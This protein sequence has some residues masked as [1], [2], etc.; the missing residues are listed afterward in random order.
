M[1]KNPNKVKCLACEWQLENI[2]DR[3]WEKNPCNRCDN[4]REVIDPKELLCNLCGGPMCPDVP[5]SNSQIPHGLEEQMV[6]GGYDS[7]HL[8]DL[9]FYSFAFCEECL[10]K[11]FMQCKIPPKVERLASGKTT[12]EI[13]F[14]EDQEI[15]EYG[16][17]VRLGGHH[18]AYLDRKCNRI[19]NCPN[20]AIYTR[21]YRGDFSEESSCEEHKD[22]YFQ[23]NCHSLVSFIPNVLKPFL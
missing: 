8:L 14:A 21:L 13:P 17:W 4:T 16:E 9:H 7:T 23:K 22:R 19:K 1:S 15:Y 10:R 12:E 5:N 20:K 2:P 3:D 11:L 18:Q 6:I